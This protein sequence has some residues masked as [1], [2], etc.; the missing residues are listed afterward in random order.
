MIFK[1]CFNVAIVFEMKAF[2]TFIE[3]EAVK[4]VSIGSVHDFLK[5]LK[6]WKLSNCCLYFFLVKTLRSSTVFTT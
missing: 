6:P 5:F 1:E 4:H 3:N 2:F